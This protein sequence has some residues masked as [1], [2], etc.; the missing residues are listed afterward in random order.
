VGGILAAFEQILVQHFV[1]QRVVIGDEMTAGVR[2][3]ERDGSAASVVP[4][5]VRT[6]SD[7]APE[8]QRL[9]D[10]ERDRP[11]R[12]VEVGGIEL[13]PGADDVGAEQPPSFGSVTAHVLEG[14]G[15]LQH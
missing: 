12:V 3:V 4:R 5:I 7:A 1:Q 14:E 6:L 9:A 2:E 15:A 13:G 8:G 11:E 10:D